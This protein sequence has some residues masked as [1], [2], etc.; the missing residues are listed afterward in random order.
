MPAVGLGVRLLFGSD[1]PPEVEGTFADP[2]VNNYITFRR[3]Q[4]GT[5]GNI[6]ATGAWRPVIW[7]PGYEED[8]LN[9]I[10]ISPNTQIS[11]Q[12]GTYLIFAKICNFASARG[13]TRLQNITDG[14]TLLFGDN[15]A[16]QSSDAYSEASFIQ[17]IFTLSVI[18]ILEIQWW[19]ISGVSDSQGNVIGPDA[20]R[21]EVYSLA[22]LLKLD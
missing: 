13:Y 9:L 11:L 6:Y 19:G 4:N 5:T 14:V 8:V 15:S 1:G 17:G 7:Q 12:P 22:E 2:D 18:K 3:Q 16:A 21:P 10:T 20:T